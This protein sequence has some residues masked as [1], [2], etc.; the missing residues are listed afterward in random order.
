MQNETVINNEVGLAGSWDNWNELVLLTAD[1]DV[2]STTLELNAG[3]LIEY[4]FV[5]S[6][7]ISD[8]DNYET[9]TGECAAS[10]K[11]VLTVPDNDTILDLVC[12][13]SCEDCAAPKLTIQEIQ[14]T[15]D[16]SPYLNQLV[17]TEGEVTQ[18]NE[19]G[20]FIQDANDV[21]SGI[22]VYN[23]AF[24]S[25]SVGDGLKVRG[26][27][28]EYNNLTEI[29][30]LVWAE[31]FTSS[32]NIVAL[33]MPQ[34]QLSEQYESVLIKAANVEAKEENEYS[35]WI[36]EFDNGEQ[37]LIDDKYYSH[38][39]TAGQLYNISGIVYFRFEKFG[40]N[41]RFETDIE[42][43]G[44]AVPP[45]EITFQ[46][47]MQNEDI[48]SDGVYLSGSWDDWSQAVNLN[49]NDLIYSASIELTPNTDVEYKFIN[50][51]TANEA[52]H[53]TITGNCVSV[54]GNRQLTVPETATTLDLV[55]YGLCEDCTNETGMHI[56][57]KNNIK[58]YPNPANNIVYID[59]EYIE[60][61]KIIVTDITGRVLYQKI[62]QQENESIHLK[63][64]KNGTYFIIIDN[65]ASKNSF[66]LNII[67]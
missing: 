8:Y 6:A 18:V 41:P 34:E 57:T 54:N 24:N 61:T 27:I 56:L 60:N 37:I 21:R 44:P 9:I 45:V 5:N 48:S 1:E 25:L 3:D 7:S 52:N 4:Q 53:E 32:Y 26:T 39:L 64:Y 51:L 31:T 20:C 10:G 65:G 46:V 13:G 15:T 59:M 62:A 19:Y 49:A 58:V 50:G 28:D 30:D 33:E 29:K 17:E 16:V 67:K 47:N 66:K 55:C 12:F 36:V 38:E 42:D 23:E 63:S 43:L 35:N 40:L 2:Y 22:M 11:R 14:G